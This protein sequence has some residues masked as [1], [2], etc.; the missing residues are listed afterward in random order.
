VWVP[1]GRGLWHTQDNRHHATLAD[2]RARTD[3]VEV[4]PE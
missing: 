4:L 1:D 2:L 3:L